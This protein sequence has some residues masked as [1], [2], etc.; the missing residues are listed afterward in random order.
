MAADESEDSLSSKTSKRKKPDGEQSGVSAKKVVEELSE[1]DEGYT[2][3][4]LMG[5]QVPTKPS[6]ASYSFSARRRVGEPSEDLS[7]TPGPGRYNSTDPNVYLRRQPSFSM[8]SRTKRPGAASSAAAAAASPGPGAHSP[9]KVRLHLPRPPSFSLG[10]R[11]SEFVTPLVL[12][13]AE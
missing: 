8:Q 12:Q 6:S 3:P 2:L 13:V 9:E 1:E 5:S 10:Q 7:R 11:H 4:N